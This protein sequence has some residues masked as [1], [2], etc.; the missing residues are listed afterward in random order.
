MIK[1]I[2]A[3]DDEGGISRNGI[4][5][6]PHNSRDMKWFKQNTVEQVVIMGRK[7]WED[8]C[9]YMPLLDRKNVVVS[10]TVGATAH[11]KKSVITTRGSIISQKQY[12]VFTHA[13]P[14]TMLFSAAQH[15]IIDHIEKSIR[16]LEKQYSNRILWIIGGGS[17]INQTLNM[18]EEFY[19]TRIAGT[20]DCDTFLPLNELNAWPVTWEEVHDEETFQILSNPK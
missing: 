12:G 11:Q 5:P 2:M 4:L 7:T 1:A 6:W 19:L 13:R 10:K 18:V 9:E 17:I 15:I 8:G 14:R 16:E 3:C 20:Y